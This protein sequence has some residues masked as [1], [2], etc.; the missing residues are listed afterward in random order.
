MFFGYRPYKRDFLTELDAGERARHRNKK[1][2]VAY[3]DE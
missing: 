3:V 2:L 1:N